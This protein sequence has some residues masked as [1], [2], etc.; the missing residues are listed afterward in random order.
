MS[1]DKD[2]NRRDEKEQHK[3]KNRERGLSIGPLHFG[4]HEVPGVML[5]LVKLGC[6]RSIKMHENTHRT[7]QRE[8][9]YIFR[10][11]EI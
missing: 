5:G 11:F 7:T 4:V 8:M 2:D 9:A 1:C 10:E 6:T 3:K